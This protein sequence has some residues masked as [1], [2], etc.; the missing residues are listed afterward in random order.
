MEFAVIE[1]VEGF[2]L[3]AGL[4]IL[5]ALALFTGIGGVLEHRAAREAKEEA[6]TR[7][8]KVA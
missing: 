7:F 5:L 8:R 3:W 6:P 4:V 2:A 1:L